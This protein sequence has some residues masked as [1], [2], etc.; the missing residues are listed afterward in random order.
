MWNEENKRIL[1]DSYKQIAYS[2]RIEQDE[3]D[4][5][6]KSCLKHKLYHVEKDGDDEYLYCQR[7]RNTYEY[8]LL[9]KNRLSDAG[10]L[11]MKIRWKD[12]EAITEN[13]NHIA[14][15][16][17]SKKKSK[18]KSKIKIKM[19][20][21]TTITP[22]TEAWNQFCDNHPELVKVRSVSDKRERKL[23]ERIRESEFDFTSI[24]TAIEEQPFLL[25]DN[26]RNWIVSFDWIIDSD[27]NYIKILE[28][29]YGDAKKTKEEA[30]KRRLNE[31]K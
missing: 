22:T 8:Y 25:G 3:I 16:S 14:S 13:N 24:L 12:N 11:G 31:K 27:H 2:N 20:R 10:K 6:I 30:L 29:R 1:K 23:K 18:I 7:L 21:T 28:R 5:F 15:K 26:D 9:K 19:K 17:K 4:K